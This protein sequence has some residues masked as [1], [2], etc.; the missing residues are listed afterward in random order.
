MLSK[1]LAVFL[2]ALLLENNCTYNDFFWPRNSLWFPS[3]WGSKSKEMTLQE[4]P[5]ESQKVGNHHPSGTL[6]VLPLC[7][8]SVQSAW[9]KLQLLHQHM[10][11]RVLICANVVYSFDTLQLLLE[12]LF[13]KNVWSIFS[14]YQL[15]Y[16]LFLFLYRGIRIKS[17]DSMNECR[18]KHF[19]STRTH[20]S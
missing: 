19:H 5:M 6:S 1:F 16:D 11:N 13:C 8:K 12:S 20:T 15:D 10:F 7:I 14:V 3:W 2:Q 9:I 4:Q 17:D 18:L